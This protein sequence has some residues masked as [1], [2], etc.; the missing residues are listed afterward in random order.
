M[1]ELTGSTIEDRY[2]FDICLG[3]GTF[4]Q[5]YRVHDTRRNVDLA[6]K[7]LRADVA[8]D[9]TF[10][11]RFRREGL[12][13]E[14]LQHPNI[15]RYYDLVETPEAVFILMDYIPGE[16]LQSVLYNIGRPLTARQVFEFLKPL[17]AALHFA[18]GEG[19]IHRDLK[20]ANILIHENGALLVTDFGIARLLDDGTFASSLGQALGTP[21]YMAPEQITSG[22]I[23]A[24][25]DIYSLGVILYQ[26]LTGTVPFT[27]RHPAAQGATL[28]ERIT[29]EHLHILPAPLYDVESSISEAVDEVVRRCLAKDPPRRPHTVRDVYDLM[30]EALGAA[31]SDLMPLP[32]ERA[33]PPP[34]IN[35]PEISQFV[36]I[37]QE[38][39]GPLN[40]PTLVS[41][42][43]RAARAVSADDESDPETTPLG[44]E[45]TLEH[46]RPT[47][48]KNPLQAQTIESSKSE[49][50]DVPGQP[51]SASPAMPVD[52]HSAEQTLPPGNRLWQRDGQPRRLNMITASLLGGLLVIAACLIL[53][54]YA[55]SGDDSDPDDAT[56]AQTESAGVD[57]P[58][59]A[60]TDNPT[61]NIPSVTPPL[62]SGLGDANGSV[63]AYATSRLN[64]YDKIFLIGADGSG[65]RQLTNTQ[66][67]N[68]TGPAWSPDGSK[69]A[70]YAYGDTQN[71]DIYLMNADGTNM[72]NVTDSPEENDRYVAWSPDGTRLVFHSNRPGEVDNSRDY[73]LYIYDLRDNSLTQLTYN[74]IDDLGPDWS[75]DGTK[76]AFHSY[77]EPR[78]RI[79]T[80]EIDGS[81]RQAV[82]P[83]SL[84][85]RAYFPTWSPDGT[86]IAFHV[87]GADSS[88][89][90][91]VMN[92]D[93]SDLHPLLTVSMDD[94]FPDWSPDGR[95]IIFQRRQNSN[96]FFSL[97]I[98]SFADDSVTQLGS[99]GDDFL[100][101]WQPVSST[102]S[103]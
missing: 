31:P 100:P 68:E 22:E 76:I 89:Q 47:Q 87:I 44:N 30:A 71:A 15:V 54:I 26:M 9:P 21:L 1:S 73:E 3:E 41:G 83:E 5:V 78:Y 34:A 101:D 19:V 2:R 63:V 85:N 53:A 79:Y 103:P 55:L 99:A 52:V 65:N 35:L 36:R 69:I 43:S 92:A 51:Y 77:I 10:L 95:Y 8:H 50:I 48:N 56:P 97:Q 72:V 18:H 86:R 94:R 27:G 93:G 23:S 102:T 42:S 58:S 98:Y 40:R 49:L 64:G 57:D 25:T 62:V 91:F 17:T 13:L 4:A 37:A 24:A 20:P 32:R 33:L 29:Y 74:N 14:R 46:E 38:A 59:A 96:N 12:V 7:V 6:A 45:I 11:E 67:M 80:V 28:S 88:T 81:N 82:S 61:L 75:P 90:I 39:E 84:T 70:F 66:E 16:T 60:A